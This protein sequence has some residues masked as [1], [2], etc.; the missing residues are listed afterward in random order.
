M[1]YLILL[2]IYLLSAFAMYKWV[3]I[4][5]YH[6]DGIFKGQ[7]VGIVEMFFTFIPLIN[8]V[9]TI[10]TWISAYPYESTKSNN[11][12]RPKNYDKTS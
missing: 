10:V 7:D 9:C 4:A 5:F 8:T 12:F 1:I 6:K 3:Q 2:T 11:F